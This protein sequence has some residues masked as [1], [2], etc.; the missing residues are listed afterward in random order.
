ME[1]MNFLVAILLGALI[2]FQREYLWQ[3]IHKIEVGGLRTFTFL[4]L[5]GA[6]CGYL[7]L[8]LSNNFYILL[9]GFAAIVLLI[10][11]SYVL[12]FLK[13]KDT[14]ATTEIAAML[15]FVVGFLTYVGPMVLAVALAI[16]VTALLTYKKRLHLYAKNIKS[17][18]L[19]AVIKFAIISLVILPFL[20]NK[21][22]SPLDIPFL[23]KILSSTSINQEFLRQ[24]NVFNLYHIWWMVILIA[25][26][27]FLGYILVKFLGTKKGYGLTGLVGGL[28]SSTAV[29]L[30]ISKESKTHKKIVIPF[31]IAVVVASSTVFIR[32]IIEV[33]VINNSLLKLIFIPLGV[34]GIVGYLFAFFLWLRKDK[35]KKVKEI[36]FTQPFAL[37][38]A[39][40]FG[41]FFAFIIFLARVAQLVAGS[42]G[43]YVT[44]I[45]S[46]L[47]D[48]DAITLTMSSLSAVGKISPKVAGITI[49]L[50][51]ASNTIV[52][53]GIS[54]FLGEKKFAKYIIVIFFFILL[55]GLGSFLFL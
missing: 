27:S 47:A 54:W 16:V 34:M 40:K 43:L 18:D 15:T 2:G 19:F 38:P 12:S 23:N 55:F 10:S 21:N 28:V 1:V 50:A 52:K 20:P 22:Y 25:G 3:H 37:A 5:F 24:L 29:T 8:K 26:I 53:A 30:S 45:I 48:V 36:E 9:M 31:V 11:I 6:L 13:Y 49:I 44:G 17:Q 33:L 32:I 42:I 51:A 4:S 7:F 41:L 39:I 35:S 14:T 46:G